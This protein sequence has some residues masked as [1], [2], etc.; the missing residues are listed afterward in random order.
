[1][2]NVI[3][4]LQT[5]ELEEVKDLS[6]YNHI[7][8]KVKSSKFCFTHIKEVCDDVNDYPSYQFGIIKD[9]KFCC[10]FGGE[11]DP[12]PEGKESTGGVYVKI[13][14]DCPEYLN[15]TNTKKG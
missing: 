1:M 14:I 15:L 13:Y 6:Y 4:E 5:R 12:V 7:V 8:H 9:E 10:L 3:F 2:M 11:G